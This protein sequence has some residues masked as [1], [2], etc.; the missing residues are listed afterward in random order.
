MK[1]KMRRRRYRTRFIYRPLLVLLLVAALTLS[2]GFWDRGLLAD[3]SSSVGDAAAKTGIVPQDNG[4]NVLIIGNNARDASNPLSLGTAGGQADI[5]IV[6]HIDS[7]SHQVTLIS[8]PRDTLVALP[9][10]NEP[11]PKIKSTFNLGLQSSPSDGPALAMKYVSDMTGMT[12][13]NYVAID[14]QGFVDAVNAVHGISIDV[15]AR[16]YDPLNSGANFYP[17][18]QVLNGEQALAYV[19]IRQNQAGNDYRINDFQRQQAE[20]QVINALKEKIYHSYSNISELSQL[21]HIVYNDVST[22]LNIGQIISLVQA[23][24][25][26]HVNY[27]YLG[28]DNDAMDIL[29]TP[30]AGLNSE[31]YLTGAW[32]DVLDP[33]KVYALLRPYGARMPDTAVLPALPRPDTI[34]VAVY[35]SAVVSARLKQAG[36]AQVDYLG[37]DSGVSSNTVVYPPGQLYWG[38]AVA[39]AEGGGD[40]VVEPGPPDLRQ[41]LYLSPV[42]G[43]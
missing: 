14:F 7:Q 31:N 28:S 34:P 26:W 43:G 12:V 11:I 5:L 35:G 23:S 8:I 2:V 9:G 3:W 24:L 38:L 42:S 39:R 16:L 29:S 21:A 20:L 15:P 27:V 22:N 41:V 25:S 10:Y 36:F 1:K 6:A 33:A 18:P 4:L 13:N 30:V 32:Y 19:R 40:E 37:P 17:G